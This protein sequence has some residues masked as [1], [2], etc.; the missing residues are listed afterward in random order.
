MQMTTNVLKRRVLAG[1]RVFGCWLGLADAAV[2]ELLAHA[3]YDFLILDQEHGPGSLETAADVMRA[4][5]A[6]GCPLVVRVPWNDPVYLKR[7]L[8]LGATSV[9]IPLL[10]GPEAAKAAV[11]A[12]RYPPHGTRGFAAGAHRCT[13]WGKDTNYLAEWNDRLLIMGQLESAQSAEQAA[14]IAAIDGID[15][16]FIGIND[17]AGSIGR[18]GQLDHPEVRELVERCEKNLRPSG[19][20]IGTVP[21]AMR[22]IPELFDAGYTLVAGAVDALLLRKAAAADV[23]AHRPRA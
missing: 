8:D 3:G 2:A 1:E 20:P 21:S 12:C 18:L 17:M 13:R 14:A 10:E 19:K 22:T 23:E 11:D 7:I 4:A 15:L 5:E 6:A 9:M 16:P